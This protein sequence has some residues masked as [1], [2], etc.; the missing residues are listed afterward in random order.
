LHESVV[1]TLPSLQPIAVPAQAPPEHVSPAVQALPSSQ[2]IELAV[3]TQ[4]VAGS[5]VSVVH[6]LL[7]LQAS[8]P[9]PGWQLPPPQVSP[10]VQ[11]LPSLQASALLVWVHP[12]ASVQESVVQGFPSSQF[13]PEPPTHAPWPLHWS[14]IVHSF[15]S[16][17]GAVLFV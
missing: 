2:P 14:P 13:G 9:N 15:A 1:H 17:H 8:V 3:K 12:V 10:V 6:A 7:S 4:P 16:S 5:H 11:A